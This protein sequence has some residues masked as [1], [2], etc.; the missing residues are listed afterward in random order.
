MEP[1]QVSDE[2]EMEII[3]FVSIEDNERKK[4]TIKSRT[5]KNLQSIR[6]SVRKK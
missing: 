1:P 5:D 4:G 6:K 3:N 2:N